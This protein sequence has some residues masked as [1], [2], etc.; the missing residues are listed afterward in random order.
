MTAYAYYPGCTLKTAS[1]EFDNSVRLVFW[2]MGLELKELPD[3]ACCGASSAHG[4][5]RLLS[6]ALP[7]R[8]LIKAAATGMPLVAPCAA[9][10]LRMKTAAYELKD[11]E[12]REAV[13]GILGQVIPED[14]KILHPLQVLDAQSNM[15][16]L[17]PLA[18]LKVACYYGCMLVRPQ[19]ILEFDDIDNPMIMDRVLRRAGMETVDWQ[20]KTECCGAGH[21]LAH[22]AVTWKLSHRILEQAKQAG[23]DCV[24]VACPLCQSNLDFQDTVRKAHHDNLVMP[25]FYFTELLGLALRFSPDELM[26][27]RHFTDPLPL[28]RSKGLVREAV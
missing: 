2:R 8:E 20:F 4:T 3:W 26:F 21:A 23:A 11:P 9:C 17:K 22:P 5:D 25:V 18:G 16:V 10:F 15:L 6:I 28:L 12:T 1:R 27:G 13:S 7:A 24:A 14:F 19:K